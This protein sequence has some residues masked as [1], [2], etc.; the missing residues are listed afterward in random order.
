MVSLRNQLYKRGLWKTTRYLDNLVERIIP[1]PA[2]AETSSIL[3]K[4]N[5]TGYESVKEHPSLQVPIV[6][7]MKV[8][9]VAPSDKLDDVG[10]LLKFFLKRSEEPFIDRRHLERYGRPEAVNIKLR[11]AP[12][13]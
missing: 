7:G 2:V 1:F 8:V 12:A 3:G 4:H 5:F 11:W 13:Y 10:A 9:N 6:K